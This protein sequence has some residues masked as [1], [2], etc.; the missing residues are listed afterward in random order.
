MKKVNLLSKKNI[1]IDSNL[2]STMPTTNFRKPLLQKC[3]VLC[4]LLCCNALIGHAQNSYRFEESTAVYTDLVGPTIIPRSAFD[5]NFNT[6]NILSPLTG[7]TFNF[8]NIP[9]TFGGYKTFAV[10]PNGSIRIDNDSSLIIIDVAFAG[11]DSIDPNSSRSYIIDG[12]PGNYIVKSQWKN[13]KINAGQAS[14]YVNL[15]TWVYQQSG[16]IE[17]HYGPSSANNASGFNTTHGPQVG[18]FYSTDNFSKCYE[19]LWVTGSPANIVLDSAANY[20]F[21]AMSGIPTNGTVYRFIPRQIP[22]S[23]DNI[24]QDKKHFSL[25]P[26]PTSDILT[27]H[28]NHKKALQIEIY[29]SSG[30]RV[31]ISSI[32]NNETIPVDHLATGI[33]YAKIISENKVQGTTKIELVR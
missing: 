14:N 13:L 8:Y 3:Y 25:L 11:M 23:I 4:F 19:K 20:S 22:T 15:Q 7:E 17:L 24:L 10:Q 21:Q 33:Y 9:F 30:K 12:I 5:P 26:N 1:A 31:L 16:I 6:H 2:S 29:T 32:R 28:T 18:I 27:L